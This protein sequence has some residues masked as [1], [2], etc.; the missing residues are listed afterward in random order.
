MKYKMNPIAL[1]GLVIAFLLFAFSTTRVTSAELSTSNNDIALAEEILDMIVDSMVTIMTL[2]IAVIQSA[3]NYNKNRIAFWIDVLALII[4]AIC[5]VEKTAVIFWQKY[6]DFICLA[7]ICVGLSIVPDHSAEKKTDIVVVRLLRA[8]RLDFQKWWKNW[9]VIFW[10]IFI[11]MGIAI[12]MHVKVYSCESLKQE[13]LLSAYTE[14]LSFVGAFALGYYLYKR[15]EIKNYEALKKKARL[16]YE[17]MYYIQ[18]NLENLDAFIERGETYPIAQDWRS[19]YLDIKRLVKQ[20]EHELG[21]ELQFFFSCIESLNKA[22]AAGDKDR[23]KKIYSNFL[24]KEKYHNTKFNYMDAGRIMLCISLD[25]PQGE[26]WKEKEKEQIDKYAELFFDLVNLRIYNY[27]MK[28]RLSSC[29]MSTI[30]YELV[31]WLLQHPELSAWVKHPFEKRK[32]T[33]VVFRIALL[34]NQKSPN[35]NFY[36]GTFSLK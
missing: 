27:L 26:T 17:S 36:W 6:G 19:D 23:A 31:E 4:G 16:I 2:V 11:T 28:K 30:E 20:D 7:L 34:M 21:N 24:Q 29:E 8:F 33:E 10:V 12:I 3:K 35:M 15:E 13:V 25:M 1:F 22:I 14:Y 9:H 18:I 32:I 5:L